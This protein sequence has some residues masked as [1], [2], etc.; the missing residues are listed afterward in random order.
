MPISNIAG[1]VRLHRDE[2]PDQTAIVY[3]D[4]KVSWRELDETS[5]RLANAMLAVGIGP[6]DRVARVEK[7]APDYFELVFATSKINAVIVDVNWRLA[8]PEI[9]QIVDDSGAKLLFVGGEFAPALEGLD[10]ELDALEAVVHLDDLGAWTGDASAEDPGTESTMDDV[11]LQLYTSGTTGLPKGVMLSNANLFSFIEEVPA[12]WL[13]T[14]D[15]VSHVVMPTFHIAG[16]GWGLVSLSQGATM[17]LDRDVDPGL[18][19]REVEQ[20]EIT[21]AIYV[22]AVLAFLQIMPDASDHDLSSME[23]I[24]YG[25]SPITED[26]L[27]GAMAQFSTAK[28]VQVYG[29]TETTG[30]VVELG[31]ED[32]DPENRPDLLRS[33]G[34]PYPWVEMRIVGTTV[35]TSPTARSARS[36]SRACRSWSATGTTRPRPSGPSPT[37]G[38]TP[39]TPA[40]DRTAT[41]SCTTG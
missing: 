23:L 20:H 16:S 31:P 39:A 2:R 13:F 37:A 33:A 35:K 29:L 25:A 11:C 32:H 27:K 5:S 3:G 17:I 30:A 7:N 1:I 34:K 21:H 19:L 15:S 40:T 10:T 12:Q 28:F 24:A 8:P 9:R 14:P 22:P 4:E 36:G 6:G 41:C 18:I 38:S 26:V